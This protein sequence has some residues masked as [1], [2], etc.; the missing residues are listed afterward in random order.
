MSDPPITGPASGDSE[1]EPLPAIA[2]RYLNGEMPNE[3]LRE[4]LAS[5][6]PEEEKAFLER[7][8]ELARQ[9][10]GPGGP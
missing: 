3:A 4:E 6:T 7:L 1:E 8:E 9:Y 2:F 5:M 10:Q